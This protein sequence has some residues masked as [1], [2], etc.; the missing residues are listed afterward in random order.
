MSAHRVH[1]SKSVSKTRLA[2]EHRY[3]LDLKRV[4]LNWY[5]AMSKRLLDSGTLKEVERAA[6]EI[7]RAP[8]PN[9]K[10][11][12]DEAA[13][14]AVS[15]R[16]RIE[17]GS[18][19]ALTFKR[20]VRMW[21]LRGYDAGAIDALGAMGV[22]ARSSALKSAFIRVDIEKRGDSPY[23]PKGQ[24]I[25]TIKRLAIYLR[26]RFYCL[27]T[28]VDLLHA[29]PADV[30]LDHFIPRHAGGNNAATNI[31]TASRLAN[32]SHMLERGM[33]SDETI[34][35]IKLHL[36]L[37]LAPYL[38]LARQILDGE[39]DLDDVVADL[40]DEIEVSKAAGTFTFSLTDAEILAALEERVTFTSID[41]AARLLEDARRMIRDHLILGREGTHQVASRIADATGVAQW[42]ALRIARTETSAVFNKASYDMFRRSGVKRHTWN[43]VGDD[44]VRDQHVRNDNVTVDIGAPFPSGQTHPGE[45]P[46][47][48]NCRCSLTPDLSD[49]SIILEPWDGS[50]DFHLKDDAPVSSPVFA[51]AIPKEATPAEVREIVRQLLDEKLKAGGDKKA[52]KIQTILEQ[53]PKASLETLHSSGDLTNALKMD[54]K[55]F[56]ALLESKYSVNP[57]KK[58]TGVLPPLIGGSAKPVPPPPVVKPPPAVKPVKPTPPPPTVDP[59]EARNQFRKMLDD[60]ILAKG[61]VKINRIEGIL[62]QLTDA[63]IT[64][65]MKD[66]EFLAAKGGALKTLMETKYGVKWDAKGKPVGKV[67]P[68]PK[69]P[70]PVQVKPSVT[71]SPKPPSTPFVYVAPIPGVENASEV[72]EFNGVKFMKVEGRW[73][74]AHPFYSG[75][76]LNTINSHPELKAV[77]ESFLKSLEIDPAVISKLQAEAALAFKRYEALHDKHGYDHPDTKAALKQYDDFNRVIISSKMQLGDA[78]RGKLLEAMSKL[79][80]GKEKPLRVVET[81]SVKSDTVSSRSVEA[82]KFIDGMNKHHELRPVD[83][84][85]KTGRAYYLRS[86]KAYTV[87]VFSEAK[88]HVHEIGHHV[89]YEVAHT[90]AKAFLDARTQGESAKSIAAWT[91]NRGYG[92]EMGKPDKFAEA[93]GHDSAIYVGK[94][95]SHNAT[96]IISMGLELMYTDPVRFAKKDPEYF[97]FIVGVMS[98]RFR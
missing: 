74:N 9:Q 35:K 70:A 82:K 93:F 68:P 30:T 7:W 59:V 5:A 86:D 24:W 13:T 64:S 44:R 38:T 6:A 47:S 12:A 39:R 48:V 75:N 31:Y 57:N 98:G 40:R 85:Q 90:M 94:Q 54:N 15:G 76:V 1:K 22:R 52:Q 18:T 16:L 88:T 58:P 77:R 10:K 60:R 63:Q 32:V 49:K 55:Q 29:D 83:V 21:N 65:L 19:E 53:L 42:R 89:E 36:S 8:L 3:A 50:E 14:V 43:T 95:Y 78:A 56:L 17:A 51:P 79:S 66:P 28:G 4:L 23:Q 34:D 25:T 11:L 41:T 84:N 69:P 27:M 81:S 73:V 96:E 71:P 33:L 2:L 26:D 37:D 46:L 87:G 62:G 61:D 20:Y 97:D 92:R 45:G 72:K 91:G 67:K 80:T